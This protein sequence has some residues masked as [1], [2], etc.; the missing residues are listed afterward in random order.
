M[1][2]FIK[3]EVKDNNIE[4][5]IRVLKRKL[6]KEGFFKIMKMKSTYEK[7]SEKKKR[8]L[9]ENIKRVKKLNKLKNR[10]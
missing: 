8:I 1:E 5:A 7:P 10:I 2:A 6:Q 9:Q 3:I 4:Q